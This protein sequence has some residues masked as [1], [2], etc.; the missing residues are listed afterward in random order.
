MSQLRTGEKVFLWLFVVTVL[1]ALTWLA[2]TV[3]YLSALP[4]PAEWQPDLMKGLPQQPIAPP[5]TTPTAIEFKAGAQFD[6]YMTIG[7][8]DAQTIT[9][10][11]AGKPVVTIKPDGRTEYFGPPDEAA[12]AFWRIVGDMMPVCKTVKPVTD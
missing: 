8:P 1:A 5:A 10:T 3:A 6:T 12:R 7:P 4:K 2:F 11:A 9:F